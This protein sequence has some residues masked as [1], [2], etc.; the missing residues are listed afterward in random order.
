MKEAPVVGEQAVVHRDTAGV[1]VEELRAVQKQDWAAMI[2][3]AALQQR[4]KEG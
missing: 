4:K 1:V 3:R 2:G